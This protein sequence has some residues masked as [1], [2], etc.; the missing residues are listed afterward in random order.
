MYQIAFTTVTFRKLNRSAVCNIAA[1]NEISL[2]EW[3]GDIHLPIADINAQ[4]EIINL[5]NS[6][7][8][9]ALSYGS[10]YYV[11]TKNY[12]E[13]RKITQTASSIGAKT[14]RVWLGNKS[15][16]NVSDSM[17][18]EMVEETQILADIAREKDLI[19]AFEFHKGTYNDN[20]KRSSAFIEKVNRDNVKTYWQP[21]GTK[22]DEENL[23]A[24]LPYL[25]SVHVFEWN[26][27]GKRYPL[28]H[29]RKK[30]K[31]YASIIHMANIDVNYIMEFVKND[32]PRRFAKD[33]V[34]LQNLLYE[35]YC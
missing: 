17:L 1:E 34:I 3:G 20:G 4:N 12:D 14:I 21:F 11:G 24:V 22:E 29:G 9:C 19:V 27:K 31:K 18:D 10:Y 13:W 32:S 2:I 33:L 7:N 23:K 30:W 25:I 15:S 16:E 28:K 6:L 5:S 8:L 26:E 35:V